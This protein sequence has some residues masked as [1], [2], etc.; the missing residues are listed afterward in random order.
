MKQFEFNHACKNWD[1]RKVFHYDHSG[2]TEF[3]NGE[4]I[5]EHSNVHCRGY[6]SKYLSLIHI[7]EPTRPY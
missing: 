1:H 2:F 4:L 5:V 6:Q 3:E 7:S